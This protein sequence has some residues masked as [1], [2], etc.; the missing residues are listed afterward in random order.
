MSRIPATWIAVCGLFLDEERIRSGGALT[1]AF[2]LIRACTWIRAFTRFRAFTVSW[3]TKSGAPTL[4]A[5][6]EPREWYAN[7]SAPSRQMCVPVHRIGSLLPRR[8][9]CVFDQLP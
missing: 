7:H 9:R 1:Q 2:T 5:R 6:C 3:T 8:R 4:H